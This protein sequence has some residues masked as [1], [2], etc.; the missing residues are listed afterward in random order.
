[1]AASLMAEVEE[2]APAL[3]PA[4]DVDVEDLDTQAQPGPSS[5]PSPTG[6]AAAAAGN[7]T[8]LSMGFYI[9]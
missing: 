2:V 6:A 4:A 3:E 7:D 5:A 9:L 8:Q 1:M